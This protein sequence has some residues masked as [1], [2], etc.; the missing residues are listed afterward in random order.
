[1][2]QTARCQTFCC[3]LAHH[4]YL[5]QC[6]ALVP[7]SSMPGSAEEHPVEPASH[8]SDQKAELID[9]DEEPA[10]DH[11]PRHST[12]P[13]KRVHS[14][15]DSNVIDSVKEQTKKRPQTHAS[16]TPRKPNDR[17]PN[18]PAVQPQPQPEQQS[19]QQLFDRAVRPICFY[20]RAE[21][22]YEF[23]NFYQAPINLDGYEWPTSEH[24]F[25]AQKWPNMPGFHVKIRHMGSAREVFEF[26]RQTKQAVRAD[27]DDEK[28]E[29]MERAV[30][31]KFMQH[32]DLMKLLLGTGDAELVE[33]TSNDRFWADGGD[34][35]GQNMLG[36]VLM[37]V[38][39]ELRKNLEHQEP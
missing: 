9:I 15:V 24:Y 3:H 16:M 23:T 4:T 11:T 19:Q 30:R 25:Q 36:K 8:P 31:A 32:T 38:R 17:V 18:T 12:P 35:S 5:L 10:G 22:Y 28:V 33:H 13:N 2:F 20:H 29:V 14:D 37:N 21:P 6:P 34:G 1:M 26:T 27:W 39:A 7:K